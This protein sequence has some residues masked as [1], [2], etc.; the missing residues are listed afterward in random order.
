MGDW[1]DF[2][3]NQINYLDSLKDASNAAKQEFF[4]KQLRD[5]ISLHKSHIVAWK[6]WA[7]NHEEGAKKLCEKHE[8]E[9]AKFEAQLGK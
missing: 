9:L 4:N 2:G 8:A 7:K 5:A 3:N 6:L 1:V